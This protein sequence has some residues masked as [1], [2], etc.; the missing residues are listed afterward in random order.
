M[1]WSSSDDKRLL[2]LLAKSLTVRE[3]AVKLGLTYKSVSSRARRL[4][5]AEPDVAAAHAPKAT[6]TSK[7][8]VTPRIE[9]TSRMPQRAD[10]SA[11]FVRV[12]IPDSHGAHIDTAAL[13]AFLKDLKALAPKQ[14]VFLGDHLDCGGVFTS[15][16]RSY[17]NEM[18]ESYADDCQAA[19]ALL[20]AVAKAAPKAE[21]HYIEGNHEQRV[22]RWAASTFPSK[23]DA[24]AML[25]VYG[26][27][28]ALDLKQR[29]IRYYKRSEQYQGISIPG[30]IRLGKCYFTHGI[31]FAKH[32]ASV[33]LD[34]FGANVVFGHVHRSMAVIGR[35]VSSDGHGA[36]CPGTL[37]K[38]Q[39]LYQHTSPTSWSHGYGVQFVNASGRFMH[40]NVPILSGQSML[41]D[42]ARHV[43]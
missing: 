13:A 12:I 15:H 8:E 21:C 27:A 30:T 11:S 37:A 25:E 31:S 40:L 17:T 19:N 20:D 26:P 23:K 9:V 42:I 2:G 34:R 7:I 5:Q 29:G 18:T 38:L 16:V 36:F 22:E 24:D 41:Q 39:P 35:T 14:I 1:I 28:K 6:K 3:V 10:L 33:H 4:R 32:A 43:G